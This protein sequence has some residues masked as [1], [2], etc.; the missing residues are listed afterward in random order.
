MGT[1]TLKPIRESQQR[2]LTSAECFWLVHPMVLSPLI[3]MVVS[4]VLSSS[5]TSLLGLEAC[6]SIS[7]MLMLLHLS[8][9]VH[10]KIILSCYLWMTAVIYFCL[11]FGLVLFVTN[12]F[13]F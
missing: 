10:R 2:K 4:K 12:V 5:L 9:Y 7:M 13:N 6:L 8:L 11:C 3:S 1:F